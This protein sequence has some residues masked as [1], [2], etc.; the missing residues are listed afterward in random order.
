MI[1]EELGSY[2]F[3]PWLRC[4]VAAAIPTVDSLESDTP[5]R[6]TLPVVLGVNERE[7]PIKA[8]VYGPG[9]VVGL[10]SR[11]VARRTPE[12]ESVDFPPNYFAAVDL[13]REDLPWLFTPLRADA[14]GRLRPW[15]VLIV[16]R[17]QPGVRLVAR[18]NGPLGVLEIEAPAV[19][20]DELPDLSESWAWAHVQVAGTP[21]PGRTLAEHLEAHP[22]LGVARL[23]CPQRLAP[24]SEYFACLV[25]AFLA[26]VRAGL[27][28]DEAV[29]D[30]APAWELANIPDRVQLPMYYRW[31]F[32]TGER[33]DFEA[34]A[35]ALRPRPVGPNVGQL[36]MDV[37]NP[38]PG[39]PAIAPGA[40]G[41]V[42]AFEGALRSTE[43]VTQPW[44]DPAR[45]PFE[46]A[47]RELLDAPF[48]ASD[49]P[50]IGPILA[51]PLYGR[52]HAAQERVPAGEPH[53]LR[54]LNLDPRYRAAAGLG[55]EVVQRDQEEL[56]EAAWSQVGDVVS[57]N[58][59]LKRAQ[60][61]RAVVAALKR[62]H[63]DPLPPGEL[64]QVTRAIHRRVTLSPRT[65]FAEAERGRLSGALL[66][67]ALR[68]FARPRGALARRQARE[69]WQSLVGKLNA[70]EIAAAPPRSA[71]AGTTRLDLV[72]GL[73]S[74][75]PEPTRAAEAPRRPWAVALVLGVL[76]LGAL[77]AGSGL[78][79]LAVGLGLLALVVGLALA[80]VG[81][82]VDP[83]AGT[84]PD[85]PAVPTDQ[86]AGARVTAEGVLAA[87]PRPFFELLARPEAVG[88]ATPPDAGGGGP[89][90][91]SQAARVFRAAAAAVLE[92][93]SRVTASRS[94]VEPSPLDLAHVASRLS[95]RLD[96][97]HSIVARVQARI[98]TPPALWQP[99]DPLDP[100]MAYPKFPR[101]MYEALAEVSEAYIVA[102]LEHI[103]PDTVT[104]LE[105]NPAV[106]QA[107]MTGVNHEMARELLWREYPTD[108]RG[109]YFRQFWDPGGRS[110]PPTDPEE[111]YDI[112]ELHGWQDE[113]RLGESLSGAVARPQL[114]LLIRGELLRR[115]PTAMIFA[116]RAQ[117]AAGG[118]ELE[119][120]GEIR[121]PVFQGWL[122]PDVR[123]LGFD[124]TAAEARG[125]NDDDSPGWYF[126]I[127]EQPTEPRFG[128]DVAS[129]FADELAPLS[130]WD[131]LT[132]GH[133]AKAGDFEQLK[134]VSVHGELPRTELADSSVA[135][136]GVNSAHMAY[137]T[138]QKPVRIAVHARVMLP[139]PDGE[140]DDG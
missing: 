15:L 46:A 114:V 87:P 21:A 119:P 45:V 9:D 137:I 73:P 63:L 129:A 14:Q 127:Q 40:P 67:G 24:K 112:P 106:V 139:R 88:A 94:R 68:R 36:P 83:A 41:Q 113:E 30:L 135:S 18:A 101:P 48:D 77:A 102:G 134:F 33:G 79:V 123:F 28:I 26:G 93:A 66:S 61:A 111:L 125:G 76:A 11:Q 97:E 86:L 29:D 71:P 130:S 138:L 56:M 120:E 37:G 52:W 49:D 140:G 70:G 38:G 17:R 84:D 12:Q 34:L 1:D 100:V 74:V 136:W 96:P 91:D 128:L 89:P 47:A 132:W 75:N 8:R 54:E 124:L 92:R 60:L 81:P 72:E 103:P 22:H 4:G 32:S 105:T 109:S 51:P 104:L 65:L 133:L 59:E 53:W 99:E 50:V 78:W 42:L 115:F 117:L 23:L 6:A 44:P 90:S 58:Q 118:N 2:T 5:S 16:V 131:E 107:F 121:W 57:A 19:P 98:R 43:S 82:P 69:G 85:P 62:K 55:T 108:Q 31:Q 122:E 25:P 7:V 3:L 126:V 10:D 80:S 64:V 110:P 39:L 35:R 95:A 13:V 27:G 116:E 20:R